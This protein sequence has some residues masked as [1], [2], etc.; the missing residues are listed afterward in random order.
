MRIYTTL[1]VAA[2]SL[3]GTVHAGAELEK[4]PLRSIITI[5]EI[6]EIAQKPW[7]SE[8]HRIAIARAAASG[9]QR[10]AYYAYASKTIRPASEF[11]ARILRG[12]AAETYFESLVN[13]ILNHGSSHI[14]VPLTSKLLATAQENFEKAVEINPKSGIAHCE[15]GTYLFYYGQ[16]RIRGLEELRKGVELDP[17]QARCHLL[18]GNALS[19]PGFQQANFSEAE[20][21]LRKAITLKPNYAIPHRSLATIYI[22]QKRWK[23]AQDELNAFLSFA[24][25]KDADSDTVALLQKQIKQG[26][27][28]TQ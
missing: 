5:K 17:N 21:E 23:N 10:D 27:S 25:Q 6:K 1:L 4:D 19:M 9:L 12:L 26:F 2:V 20:R 22:S 7:N 8:E 28:Q 11:N 3:L 16:E 14:P 13:P 18:L 15:W 24:S